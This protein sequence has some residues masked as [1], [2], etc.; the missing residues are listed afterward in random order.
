[1]G[2]LGRAG[3]PAVEG[4][5]SYQSTAARAGARD[6]SPVTNLKGLVTS[7]SPF[8]LSDIVAV[9][10]DSCLEGGGSGNGRAMAGQRR[11]DE[12]RLRLAMA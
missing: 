10:V 2:A 5:V 11:R 8:S 6:S 1:M 3:V 4:G 7:S 9:V 12:V